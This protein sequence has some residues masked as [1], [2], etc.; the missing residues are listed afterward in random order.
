M[1][2]LYP[3]RKSLVAMNFFLLFPY[4][5]KANKHEFVVTKWELAKAAVY[6]NLSSAMGYLSVILY[7]VEPF[8][9]S[10]TLEKLFEASDTSLLDSVTG[11]CFS[12]LGVSGGFFFLFLFK[13]KENGFNELCKRM[14]EFDI[15]EDAVKEAHNATIRRVK[16]ISVLCLF[17]SIVNTLYIHFTLESVLR[18]VDLKFPVLVHLLKVSVFF[19]WIISFYSPIHVAANFVIL[20]VIALTTEIC[21]A[22][23]AK[24]E[25]SDFVWSRKGNK[26]A[27]LMRNIREIKSIC[28]LIGTLNDFLA[29]FALIQCFLC[30][31][32]ACGSSF[33]M[34]GILFSSWSAARI[35][36]TCSNALYLIQF[37]LNSYYINSAGQ[38]LEDKVD[39]M[40]Y[41]LQHI[42][43]DPDIH[44]KQSEQRQFSGLLNRLGGSS[45]QLR[46]YS[47]FCV[48]NS[49]FLATVGV[50]ITYLIVLM[51]FK[52]TE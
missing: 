35:S 25:K 9:G 46:P 23:A 2:F 27:D 51:Q 5:L 41:H 34:S 11:L 38:R 39:D 33:N 1:K 42:G 52:S 30:L 22:S 10:I 16:I 28:R 21:D 32:L 50:I 15:E 49:S 4:N 20:F 44:L 14:D 40:K 36:F 26:L 37:M 6:V 17:G 24:M 45:T 19:N 18:D 7:Q 29:P 8:W 43:E 48:N 47:L 13:R 3:I 31:S 12:A